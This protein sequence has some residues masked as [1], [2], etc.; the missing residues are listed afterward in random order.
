MRSP[1]VSRSYDAAPEACMHAVALL[2]RVTVNK[3]TAAGR[4]PSPDDRDD[5]KGRSVDDFRADKASLPR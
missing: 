3:K 1:R 4:L 2:L 5:T